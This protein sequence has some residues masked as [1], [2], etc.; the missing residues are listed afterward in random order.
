[1]IERKVKGKKYEGKESR[2]KMSFFLL[3]G[4]R[5]N[6]RIWMRNLNID[7]LFKSF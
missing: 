3:F 6:T 2:K 1:L 7:E 5:K 4:S